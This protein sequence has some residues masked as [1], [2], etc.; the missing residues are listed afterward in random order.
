MQKKNI[1][2]LD[3]NDR[4]KT[5]NYLHPPPPHIADQEGHEEKSSSDAHLPRTARW[6]S[7][8]FK[9]AWDE[10]AF[11]EIVAD[12]AS[13]VSESDEADNIEEEIH[14]EKWEQN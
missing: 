12:L 3:P 11:Y 10:M 13:G 9:T 6:A 8:C 5:G 2:L 14:H 7:A 4:S 1:V